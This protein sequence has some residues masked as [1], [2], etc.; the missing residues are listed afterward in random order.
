MW[1][2]LLAYRRPG[3]PKWY[4]HWR[5]LLQ[6]MITCNTYHHYF[7]Y[8]IGDFSRTAETFHILI[9]AV[10]PATECI[11]FWV[12]GIYRFV[13]HDTRHMCTS[14]STTC[15]QTQWGRIWY[16]VWCIKSLTIRADVRHIILYLVIAIL[17][18]LVAHSWVISWV[19]NRQAC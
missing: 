2:T 13:T 3:N 12:L 11:V 6:G 15:I 16:R 19:S 7:R 14:V 17:S 8:G 4:H 5:Y 9:T 1:T 18:S 10:W